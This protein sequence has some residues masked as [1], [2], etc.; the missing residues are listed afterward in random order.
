MNNKVTTRGD[1][2][3]NEIRVGDTIYEYGYGEEAKTT[4]KTLPTRNEDGLWE[5]LGETEDGSEVRYAVHED[6]PHYA[7]KLYTYPAYGIGVNLNLS[8]I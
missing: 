6:F 3:V 8:S 5:W 7:P 2:I 4:V 1:V